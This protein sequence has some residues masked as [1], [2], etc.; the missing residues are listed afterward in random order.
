MWSFIHVKDFISCKFFIWPVCQMYWYKV[1]PLPHNYSNFSVCTYLLLFIPG[2]TY[3][4]FYS[5]FHWF[6]FLLGKKIILFCSFFS[7]GEKIR[8]C[9]FI[10][11][12][13]SLLHV[14]YTGDINYLFIFYWKEPLYSILL[15][16]FH[17]ERYHLALLVSVSS[18]CVTI[19]LV[20]HTEPTK[21]RET[22]L[23]LVHGQWE[24]SK[25]RT[26]GPLVHQGSGQA[27]SAPQLTSSCQEAPEQDPALGRTGKLL[28]SAP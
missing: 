16:V 5:V 26:A 1:V 27:E 14:T 22:T 8:I 9:D 23:L 11:I 7:E 19:T 2:L 10:F 18:S 20:T 6:L 28:P 17:G 24:A 12:V 4:W 15:Q 21:P 3:L 13:L 25:P